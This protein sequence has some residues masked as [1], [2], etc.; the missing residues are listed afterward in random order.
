MKTYYA[1]ID[2]GSTT[3][4]LV[5]IILANEINC[6]FKNRSAVYAVKLVERFNHSFS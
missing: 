5:V 6:R 1:G 3:T 2:T 4:K